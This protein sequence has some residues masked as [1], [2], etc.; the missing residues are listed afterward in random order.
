MFYLFLLL[1][2]KRYVAATVGDAVAEAIWFETHY[3]LKTRAAE[4]KEPHLEFDL[5]MP[6]RKFLSHHLPTSLMAECGVAGY[7][8]ADAF[9]RPCKHTLS[10]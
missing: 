7:V 4:L 6:E 1:G 8:I 5:P 3:N 2:S 9:L 10:F